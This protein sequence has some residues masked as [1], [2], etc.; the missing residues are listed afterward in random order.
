MADRRGYSAW[1]DRR[2]EIMRLLLDTHILLW[3]IFEPSKLSL[4]FQESIAEPENMVSVS[5]VSLWEI[6]IK[7]S[8]ERLAIPDVFFDQIQ[9]G[10]IFELL[11]MQPSHIHQYRQLPLLHRDPF[12][13]ML[14]AQAQQEHLTLVTGDEKILKYDGVTFLSD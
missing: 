7:Q 14:I 4:S 11:L 2:C 1:H 3:S 6:A 13:R 9:N 12:D 5:I 8:I 10:G